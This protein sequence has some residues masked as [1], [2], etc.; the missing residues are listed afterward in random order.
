MPLKRNVGNSTGHLCYFVLFKR[1]VNSSLRSGRRGTQKTNAP[2]SRRSHR[3]NTER[4]CSYS[5]RSALN[6]RRCK[7]CRGR[8]SNLGLRRDGT[9]GPH[10]VVTMLTTSKVRHILV[11]T[12]PC[13][14]AVCAARKD[15]GYKF[16]AWSYW[17]PQ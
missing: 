13:N 14:A 17:Q 1:H 5:R 11:G 3:K 6:G 2:R 8:S 12:S 10:G 16:S 4:R 9:T 15:Q 7:G